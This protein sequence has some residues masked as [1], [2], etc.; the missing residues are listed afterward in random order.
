MSPQVNP[1]R[2]LHAG[3]AADSVFPPVLAPGITHASTASSRRV[4][5][6]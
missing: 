4:L 6:S 3:T 2:L 1:A 5:A